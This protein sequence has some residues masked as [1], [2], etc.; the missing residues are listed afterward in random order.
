MAVRT[1]T[2]R[3]LTPQQRQQGARKARERLLGL[4]NNPFMTVEQRQ[5]VYDKIGA[6]NLWEQLRLHDGYPPST[7]TGKALQAAPPQPGPVPQLPTRTPQHHEVG[8]QETVP[9]GDKVT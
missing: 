7:L 4:L 8:I 9:T 3:D 6:L 5:S 2:Y 1:L